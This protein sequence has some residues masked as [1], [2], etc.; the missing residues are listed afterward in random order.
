[1]VTAGLTNTSARCDAI[2]ER[3]VRIY[4]AAVHEGLTVTASQNAFDALAIAH[5]GH[6]HRH[7]SGRCA[8]L[9]HQLRSLSESCGECLRQVSWHCIT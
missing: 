1:M 8:R 5:L 9:G 4:V 7:L 3:D 6:Q 2:F